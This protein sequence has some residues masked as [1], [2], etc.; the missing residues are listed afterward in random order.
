MKL[1][2]DTRTKSS[3][4]KV[5]VLFAGEAIIIGMY[6][7]PLQ[8][9]QIGHRGTLAVHMITT[10]VDILLRTH[11]DIEDANPETIDLQIGKAFVFFEFTK[12]LTK[13]LF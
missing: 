8:T 3:I 11:Q 9:G 6:H 5:F 4:F 2:R 1:D 12:I 13:V 10:M 7:R